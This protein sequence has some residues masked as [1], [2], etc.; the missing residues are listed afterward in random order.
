MASRGKKDSS[1]KEEPVLLNKLIKNRIHQLSINQYLNEKDLKDFALFVISNYKEKDPK[2]LA[3][4]KLKKAI[5]ERFEVENL[6]Q[7]KKS[8]SF[9]LATSGI[10]KIDFNSRESLEMLY[11]KLIGVLPNEENEQGY[12]CING[13]DIFKYDLPWKAFGLNPKTATHEEV[14]NTYRELSK[15]YH[16]DIPNTG[17]AEIFHRLTIFY[18][19]LTEKF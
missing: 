1:K 12:A 18:E 14:K 2:P 4:T 8:G 11:R 13:I 3:L 7:L 10:E 15:I 6:T 5:F 19:S 9:Q 16:P 17:D